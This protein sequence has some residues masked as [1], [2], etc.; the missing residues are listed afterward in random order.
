VGVGEVNVIQSSSDMDS[1]RPG[2]ILVTEITDPD[3]EPL[4][5]Q[6]AAVVTNAGGRTSHAAIVARELGIPA[7]VGT[8][9]ATSAL[10]TGQTVTVSCSEGERGKVYAGAVPYRIDQVD[11][12][13]LP[14]TK[15]KIMMIVGDPQRV[16]DYSRIPQQGVGLVRQELI[17]LNHIKIHPLALLYPDRVSDPAVRAQI[18]ELTSAFPSPPEYFTAKL[19]EGIGKIAAAFYPH[20]V[21]VRL[22]DF[23]SNEYRSLLGGHDFEPH[24]ENPM[25]GWR[26]A[27]RYYSDDY[28]A[29]FAL[30]CEALRRVRID[31]GLSHV[32]LMVPFCRTPAEGRQVPHLSF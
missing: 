6:A 31:M 12:G 21:I 20:D 1:F 28:K 29:A 10:K 24:E 25:L 32:K 13:Q 5:K 30:E 3:W 26:G 16:F 14:P 27:S 15:T 11:V 7:I 9:H 2:Q 19:A 18:E 8:K 22:S 17:I 23:K 4:I